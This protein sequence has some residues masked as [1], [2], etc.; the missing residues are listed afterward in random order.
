PMRFRMACSIVL[1]SAAAVSAES[2]AGLNWT[3]PAGWKNQ[4][5]QPLRAATYIVAPVAG[6]RDNAE[7]AV[8][9]FGAGQGGSVQ[10]NIDRWKGQFTAAD[11]KPAAAKVASRTIHALTVTTIDT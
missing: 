8:Y 3:A 2:V 5:A 7:C 9:F 4:G 11:G 10:A 1:V 6:D